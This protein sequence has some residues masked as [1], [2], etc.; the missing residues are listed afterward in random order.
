MKFEPSLMK[1]S[2]CLS[3]ALY[4]ASF[5]PLS[6]L[7]FLLITLPLLPV[8]CLSSLFS[9][10]KPRLRPIRRVFFPLERI[11]EVAI[12]EEADRGYI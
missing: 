6:L 5:Y 3:V 7:V 2:I 1:L 11:Q 9:P 8:P 4:L 10:R 12:T